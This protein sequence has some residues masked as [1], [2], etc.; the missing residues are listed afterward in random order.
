V[1]GTQ[2]H[3]GWTIP[4]EI[5]CHGHRSAAT[6]PGR[7]GYSA[8]SLH[9]ELSASQRSVFGYETRTFGYGENPPV[10]RESADL[11]L[12]RPQFP[13]YRRPGGRSNGGEPLRADPS[14]ADVA[15]LLNAALETTRADVNAAALRTSGLPMPMQQRFFHC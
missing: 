5:G 8:G 11:N 7:A 12:Q 15:L 13:A 3:V 4:A 2:C 14:P 6:R 9:R 1:S 10:W